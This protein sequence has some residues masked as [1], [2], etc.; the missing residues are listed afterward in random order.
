MASQGQLFGAIGGL[1]LGF[2]FG[3][4]M[5]GM[6]IGGMLGLWLDP[7]DPPDPDPLGDLGVNSYVRDMPVPVCFGREKVYGGVIYLGI[8]S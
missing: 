7:P 2:I 5:M 1:V 6:S 8:L 3:N 4:P